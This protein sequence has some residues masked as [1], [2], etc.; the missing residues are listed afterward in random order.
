MVGCF[1]I[2]GPLRQN[3]SLYRAVSQR[4]KE[5]RNGSKQGLQNTPPTRKIC[6]KHSLKPTQVK[7]AIKKNINSNSTSCTRLRY[8]CSNWHVTSLFELYSV[9][10]L[11][12]CHINFKEIRSCLSETIT[13]GQMQMYT[14][15]HISISICI[16][17]LKFKKFHQPVK[18]E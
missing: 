1:G 15:K 12:M 3:F 13:P 2:I 4:A 7:S 11:V 16:H 8:S 5:T 6:W 18:E 9:L 14:L 10:L 17:I